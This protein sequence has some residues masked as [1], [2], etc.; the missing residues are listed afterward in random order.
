MGGA[1]H[2][3]ELTC[4]Q[5]SN[6]LKLGIYQLAERPQVKRDL[7]FYEQIRDSAASAPRNIA[8]GFAR[9]SRA[10]FARFL[11]I[12]RG[13]LAESQNHLQDAMDR[14]YIEALVPRSL[15][16][17]VT[18]ADRSGRTRPRTHR[19]H[20]R[21]L[22]LSHLRT[23]PRTLAPSHVAAYDRRLDASLGR[24]FHGRNYCLGIGSWCADGRIWRTCPRRRNV[25]SGVAAS[26][27]SRHLR[28]GD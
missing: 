19:P 25:A 7:K 11:D 23:H 28:C 2:F 6:E 1:R 17:S 18:C 12:A 27:Q 16:C 13:S 15:A 24:A 26:P 8:E 5:L 9:R 10:D 22:A 3:R 14:G 21:T 20:P 4:W